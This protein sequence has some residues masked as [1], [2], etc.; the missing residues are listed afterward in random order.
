MMDMTRIPHHLL[1]AASA[2]ASRIVMALVQ[3]A[4]IRV[5]MSGL[6]LEQYAIFAL[7]ISLMGWFMLA[8]MGVGAS[9][10]NHISEQ[11]AK[12]GS[13]DGQV[14]AAAIIAAILLVLTIVAL[15][16]SSPYIAP[17][18]LKQFNFV[19][20]LE[21][22]SLFFI[23]G[24]MFIG[25][26]LGGMVYKVWYAKQK[27]YL[28][29][30]LPAIA[31]LAGYAGIVAV[32]ASE[33]S[34]KLLLSLVA[35]LA[36]SA[37][38]PL[39]A[40]VF[41]VVMGIRNGASLPGMVVV[42][43]ILKRAGH[44]WFFSLMAALVLQIDY[45]VMSQFL[46][47]H[48][49]VAYNVSTKIF[50]L[51]LFMYVSVLTALWPVFSEAIARGNW[52]MVRSHTRKYLEFGLGFVLV[53]T[54]LLVWLMPKAIQLLVPNET[55]VIPVMFI[56][57]LGVYQLL[58]VWT[59]TFAMILQ[60]MSDLKPLWIFVPIQALL[61]VVLQWT[62]VPVFGLYGI[63]FGLVGSFVLTVTWA[64]PL[65]VRRHYRNSGR[66]LT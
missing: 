23:S 43:K 25:T 58:R 30:I 62:L 56:L 47:P 1:V 21:K 12:A 65:A 41:Q 18:F 4:S 48:D 49:I 42:S 54:I 7:L 17:V 55:V 15:Y 31:A 19:S 20:D 8:D 6:G 32:N 34:D 46:N 9:L 39:G 28:S 66:S 5:L 2:W 22:N 53:S 64:L 61:S 59:D 45:L 3:L 57:L 40:F 10:Q 52:A 29:N 11:R 44:F 50:G 60:S 35:Y 33:A 26:A 27:G 37:A 51:V 24:A 13:Y 16:V 63:L 14:A 36:P 38:L